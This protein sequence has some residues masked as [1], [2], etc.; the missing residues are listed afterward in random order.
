MASCTACTR[1]SGFLVATPSSAAARATATAVVAK[2]ARRFSTAGSKE[3]PGALTSAWPATAS[4]AASS[5]PLV[6]L[7]VVFSLISMNLQISVDE[8]LAVEALGRPQRCGQMRR[9]ARSATPRLPAAGLDL[10]FGDF[11]ESLLDKLGRP[12]HGIGV[13]LDPRYEIPISVVVDLSAGAAQLDVHP[14]AHEVR[15]QLLV[16]VPGLDAAVGAVCRVVQHDVA[17][18]GMED[19]DN[20]R[21]RAPVRDVVSDEPK[22]EERSWQVFLE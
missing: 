13:D 3:A 1:S 4:A 9:T 14:A 16:R 10:I 20:L 12:G 18:V 6:T 2:E 15:D 17:C 7:P 22:V 19:H 8:R 5:M 21:C 11:H